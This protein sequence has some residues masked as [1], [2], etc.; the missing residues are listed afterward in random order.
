MPDTLRIG[1]VIAL[2]S[3]VLVLCHSAGGK[4]LA[5]VQY[6]KVVKKGDVWDFH[7]TVKHDDTGW[8]H[9]AD[10]WRITTEEGEEIARRVLRHPHIDEQPFTRSLYGVSIPEG[11]GIIMIEAHDKVHGYGGRTVV[12][13]LAKEKGPDYEIA[14]K[15]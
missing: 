14:I 1:L 11:V 6:V 2:F 10:W 12:V 4:S 15:D 7:V 9:Y 13:D 3:T 5:D 8:D